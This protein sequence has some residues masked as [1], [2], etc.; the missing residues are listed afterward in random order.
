MV[1][2]LNK[3]CLCGE[4]IT[5]GIRRWMCDTCIARARAARQRERYWIKKGGYYTLLDKLRQ[6]TAEKNAMA[7]V[8]VGIEGGKW[9]WKSKNSKVRS[10][11]TFSTYKEC[12]KDVLEAFL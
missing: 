9:F 10:D 6:E 1:K 5:S 4:I 11:R 7:K 12:R 3:C 8:I 2:K